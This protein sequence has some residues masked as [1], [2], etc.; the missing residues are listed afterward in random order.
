MTTPDPGVRTVRATTHA[1]ITRAQWCPTHGL[2][3]TTVARVWV[4]WCDGVAGPVTTR[5]C[6]E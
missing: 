6:D 5:R 2:P 4:L 3:H 1:T